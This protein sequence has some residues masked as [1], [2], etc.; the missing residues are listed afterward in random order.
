MDINKDFVISVLQR[1]CQD[2]LNNNLILEV[3]FLVEQNKT[4]ECL[5]KIANLEK[6]VE[7]LSKKKKKDESTLDGSSY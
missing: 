3:N 7:S 1:K 4:K 5:E 2:L 6:K